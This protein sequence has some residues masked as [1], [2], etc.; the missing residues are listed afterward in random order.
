MRLFLS[1]DSNAG[2]AVKGDD[3]VSVFNGPTSG[4]KNV[5]NSMLR[6]AF[7]QGGRRLDAFDTVLPDLYS[8]NL[9]KAIV[10]LPWDDKEAPNGWD[11][12]L[13]SRWKNGEPDVV[14]MAYDPTAK[15]YKDGDG[16]YA[17]SY[18][19]AVE[20]QQAAAS[21]FSRRYSA[22]A[23]SGQF[24]LDDMVDRLVSQEPETSPIMKIWDKF[25][26]GRLEGETRWQA[27]TRNAVNR[28][29]PGYLLDNYVNGEIADPA[30][31][32]GRAMELSQSMTGRL[33]ALAELGAMK[34]NPDTGTPEVIEAPDNM[35]LRQIFEPIGEKYMREYYAYAI[36][37]R[38][39]KL[40]GQGRKGFKNL[41]KQ[42]AAKIISESEAKYP[43]FREV[44]NN[45]ALFNRRMV[46]MAVDS[47]L[48]TK[49]Q[50]DN[51]MDMDYVPYYRYAESATD[52]SEFSKA[53][54]AKAH[55]SL[56]D[57]NVFEKELEGGTIKLGDMYENITKN[58]GLIV[59]ASLKNYAMQ[60]TADA[61][62]KASAMDGPKSWGRKAKEGET[63]QMI[64]FYR[65]GEK[66]R[67][68]I[69]DP[70]LWT[71]VAGLTAKQ[72]E[73]LDQRP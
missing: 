68:K 16:E 17:N 60:K 43:F 20:I 34:F 1:G 30:N 11:K 27:F 36:A 19:E 63:G 21:R 25:F 6:L 2:F 69:D 38:E 22:T 53:M 41:N 49:D 71:A 40:G 46:Q 37:K 4:L 18:D 33:W 35:G 10:R 5:T 64:T 47:G 45:Y 31:S 28:F 12:E 54:A 72:K 59:S 14:F 67:Y 29:L 62:D 8:N 39:L 58:A 50:G 51:F 13:F 56:K 23:P 57:P 55:Q 44:H 32:V 66:V 15:P 24:N 70:A 73:S 48:I 52:P 9:F 3:I 7:E 61:L 42:D 26:L 65:N